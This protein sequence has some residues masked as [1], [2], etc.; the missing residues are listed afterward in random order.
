[1]IHVG[2]HIHMSFVGITLKDSLCDI[3]GLLYHTSNLSLILAYVG[4]TCKW[5]ERGNTKFQ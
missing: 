4:V 1:M 3:V 5:F 2:L